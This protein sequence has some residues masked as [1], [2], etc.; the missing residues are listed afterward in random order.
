MEDSLEHIIQKKY[1]TLSPGQKKAAEYLSRNL[2]YSALNTAAEIGRQADV[3]ETTVIRL[4]YALGFSGFAEMQE[5]LRHQLLNVN[6]KNGLETIPHSE[7]SADPYCE[8]I[9]S[10]MATLKQLFAIERGGLERVVEELVTSDRVLVVG[11]R[12]SYAAAY[13]FSWVLGLLREN[14]ELISSS[15]DIYEKILT[16]TNKSTL[17]AISFPRY[18]RETVQLAQIAKANGVK[19]ISVTDKVLSPIGRMSD[20]TLTTTVNEK[21][22]VYSAT[23]VMSLLN[24]IIT[25]IWQRD[26]RKI[27]SRLENLERFYSSNGVFIE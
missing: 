13:W 18:T 5:L 23:S 15:G 26:D 9:E 6:A 10:E 17:F 20:F 14:V 22:G 3:S 12:A 8:V 25:G 1:E 4:S 11:F 21:S 24:L 27:R 16:L 19:V 7:R 2:E